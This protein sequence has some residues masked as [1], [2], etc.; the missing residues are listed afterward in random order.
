MAGSATKGR[1]RVNMRFLSVTS[2]TSETSENRERGKFQ[3][4][5]RVCFQTAKSLILAFRLVQ[6]KTEAFGNS[7]TLVRRRNEFWLRIQAKPPLSFII[8]N[9]ATDRCIC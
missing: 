9:V 7:W 6:A 2:E 4:E 5:A 1:R 3:R 8:R